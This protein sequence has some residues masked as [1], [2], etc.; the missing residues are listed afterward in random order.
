M[1]EPTESESKQTLDVYIHAL[2]TI[3]GEN[4]SLSKAAPHQTTVRRIDEVGAVKT[5]ILT[6]R[7]VEAPP[8]S[9]EKVT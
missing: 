2:I 5:P 3:A 8:L 1:I 6:W 4:A 7:A 9:P